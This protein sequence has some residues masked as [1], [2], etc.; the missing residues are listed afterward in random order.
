MTSKYQKLIKLFLQ[1]NSIKYPLLKSHI[2]G[3]KNSTGRNNSGKITVFHKGGG[4]KQRYRN[5][6]FFRNTT[7]TSAI[8][9]SLEYDPFRNA[10]IAA[11][12]DIETKK[13]D[14]ILAP[15]NLKVGHVVRSG[16]NA[17]KHLG[18]QLPLTKI[19]VGSLLYNVSTKVNGKAIF[20]RSAGTFSQL[21]EK[22]LTSCTL[23]L[24]SGTFYTLSSDC[25]AFIGTVS[26]ENFF[27]RKIAKAGRSRWLNQRPTVRGVAMNPVDHPHGGGE[28]KKSKKRAPK[29]PWGKLVFKGSSKH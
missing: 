17:K 27:L 25:Q 20:S 16:K 9:M 21:I 6:N 3:L 13:Y 24:Q 11:T 12:F 29:T 22:K 28:G 1:N 26:N 14:Y 23:K 10:N 8:V 19:P 4:H 15:K 18:H 7:N 5:I 2:A